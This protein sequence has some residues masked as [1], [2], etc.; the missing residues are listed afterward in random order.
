MKILKINSKERK[1]EELEV[2]SKNGNSYDSIHN[3]AAPFSGLITTGWFDG[4]NILYCDD[5]GLLQPE[6]PLPGFFIFIS[7][8]QGNIICGDAVVE[9]TTSDGSSTDVSITKEELEK[10]IIFTDITQDKVDELLSM[11]QITSFE[12]MEDIEQYLNTTK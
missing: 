3:I 1:I 2:S 7:Q 8:K 9:G 10:K 5:E 4:N 11:T 12:T 6:Y